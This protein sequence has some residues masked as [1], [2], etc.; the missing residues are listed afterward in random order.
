MTGLSTEGVRYLAWAGVVILG[1]VLALVDTRAIGRWICGGLL[2]MGIVAG[3]LVTVASPFSFGS[4]SHYM[5]GVII[6]GGSALALAGYVTGR[7]LLFLRG[8]LRRTSG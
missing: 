6:S 2:A 8:R 4:S 5:E 7:A 3:L 1:M